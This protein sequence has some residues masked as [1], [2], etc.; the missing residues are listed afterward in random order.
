[1]KKSIKKIGLW[2][3]RHLGKYEIIAI[4]LCFP[5]FI[6]AIY[7][8]PLPQVI[9]V[10]IGELLTYYATAFGILGS[11]I[12]YRDELNKRN[13]EREKELKP[14]LSVGVD[15]Q[16]DN[17]F[18]IQVE[19][20]SRYPLYFFN[21]YDEFVSKLMKA[22]Y[23]LRI[24]YNL[25]EDEEKELNPHYNITVDEDIIDPKDGFP[26]YIQILCDDVDGKQWSCLFYKIANGANPYYYPRDWERL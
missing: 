21:I 9:P 15:K 20:N 6:G 22:K 2:L 24:S 26:K 16:T 10:E 25:Y 17:T 1:M 8:L 12:L 7:A 5:L 18:L 3:D 19:N 4:V 13:K 11:F 14:D 23:S